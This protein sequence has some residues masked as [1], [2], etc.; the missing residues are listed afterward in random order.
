MKAG[1][2][3]VPIDTTYPQDRIDYI[4]E[5]TNSSIVLS[6]RNI[7]GLSLPKNK[8]LNI[9]LDAA[10]YDLEEVSD[11]PSYSQSKDL[12]YV[13]YTSGTTGK[14][15]GTL[16]NNNSFLNLLNWYVKESNVTTK[17][18]FLLI[19][20]ILIQ[21]LL[22]LILEILKSHKLTVHRVLFIV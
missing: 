3:Y 7:E 9:D 19:S 15:K 4:L 8:T 12:I 20:A 14:P 17:S 5:D 16:V 2:A 13:I 1:G 11:L 18:N 10:F 21:S 22:L 6:K